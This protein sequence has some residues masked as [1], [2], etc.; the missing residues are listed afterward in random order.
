MATVKINFFKT[1]VTVEGKTSEKY[2]RK[3]ARDEV[4]KKIKKAFVLHPEQEA[5]ELRT[6]TIEKI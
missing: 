5:F 6:Y 1:K 3:L 2:A 4:S